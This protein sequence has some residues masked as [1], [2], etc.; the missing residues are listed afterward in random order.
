MLQVLRR[1]HTTMNTLN[2]CIEQRRILQIPCLTQSNESTMTRNTYLLE[3]VE[4]DEGRV[5]SNDA[6]VT[7]QTQQH[8]EVSCQTENSEAIYKGQEVNSSE[9]QVFSSAKH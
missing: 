9:S 1:Q 2:Q 5:R 8:N 4:H 7:V 6:I 3:R